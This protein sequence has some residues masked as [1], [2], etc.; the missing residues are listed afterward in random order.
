MQSIQ[1][2]FKNI[3]AVPNSTS[4]IDI[5]LSKTQRK[6]PTVV[7]AGYKITRI[8]KFYM[9]KIKFTYTSIEEKID[10]IVSNFPKLDDIHPF[11][12]DLINILYDKD[13]YKMALGFLNKAKNICDKITNDYVKLMKYADSL[14]RCKQ[15]KVAALGRMAT[16]MKKLNSSLNYLEEV[17]KHL[18]RLPSIDPNTRTLILT[19]FPNVGK[20]SFM[21]KITYAGSEVQ[22]YPFTTQSLFAGHTYFKNI[23]WQ[24]ID[25]PGILDRPLEERNTIE[26][27]AI[28]ALAHLEACILYFIDISEICGYSISE[29]IKLFTSI[30]PLFKNKPLVLV[31]NKTDLKPYNE[32]EESD[33]QVLENL[34]KEH[35]TYMIQMSNQTGNG[36]ADVKSASCEILLE[37]RMAKNKS[38]AAKESSNTNNANKDITGL[39]KIYVAQPSNQRDN[40]RRKPNIPS[41]VMEE[42]EQ[43]K[44]RQDEEINNLNEEERAELEEKILKEGETFLLEKKIKNNRIKELMEQNGGDG[45]FF[46]PD[47]E[48]FQLANPEWKN[49]VWPEFMDGKNV[50]DFVD[51]DIMSKLEVLE[52]E[53][54]EHRNKM[55]AQGQFEDESDEESSELDEE[56]LEAHED[57]MENKKI[58]RQKHQ[59][60]V[61]SQLPR[62]VRDLTATEKFMDTIR[63]DKQ[64]GNKELRLL[65][66][67]KRQETKEKLKRSLLND[68]KMEEDED[69]DGMGLE[70]DDMMD[71]DE[72]K[73]VK[74][75]KKA[76]LSPEDL[77]ELKKKKKIEKQ[78]Q[79]T[80]ERM[81]RKIQ[82]SWNRESRVNE[83]DRQ[84]GTKLPKHLNSGKRGIGKTDRR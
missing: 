37:F 30:K 28:T 36:V 32:L 57:V 48:H 45:V 24:V 2:N 11:Y 53:E 69:E 15:L 61:G 20:S 47:R 40:R 13:H 79:L 39:D 80:V 10:S 58:I 52:R 3:P 18:G 50:F 51:P 68:A 46:I 66:H 23:K 54:D 5:V 25:T 42:K 56:L 59:L 22:P 70:E 8:R 9:R 41:S 14:Y 43:E 81:K 21:N 27:Q 67:K 60:V 19:G 72:D 44:Q 29:Q 55:E 71:I 7:H 16:T 4:L 26:M 64:E 77:K 34:A 12:G 31:L 6:T 38:K 83:A 33:K 73:P 84:V 75:F 78:K 62:R 82:K 76:R 1:Y 63:T 17:R 65:S 74:K 35:N 49:D